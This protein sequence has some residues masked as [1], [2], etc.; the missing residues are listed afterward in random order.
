VLAANSEFYRAFAERDT[1][2]MAA[3]WS[4]ASPVA[5]I[6]P[7]WD[8]LVER[9]MVIRSWTQILQNPKAPKVRCRK[10]QPFVYGDTAFVVCQEI[11]NEGVLA[12]T[13]VF[14]REGARWKIIHH[15]SSP[16]AL[17]PGEADDLPPARTVH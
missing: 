10:A 12:A 15:Q 5:C 4:S 3:L 16:L 8:A 11:L 6:H 1:E 13:N 17:I 14:V 7:G 9:D 2:A